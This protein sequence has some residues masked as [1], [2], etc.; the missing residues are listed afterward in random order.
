MDLTLLF[1]APFS[2]ASS[3]ATD[4]VPQR[5]PIALDG[6]PYMV[7]M[8]S[9]QTGLRGQYFR[10]DSLPVLRAQAD[11]SNTPSEASINPNDLWRRSLESWKL[12][13]GQTR[14]DRKSSDGRRFHAS[15][16][17]D[18]WS[19]DWQIS[20]LPD[21]TVARAS[22]NSNLRLVSVGT[23]CYLTDGQGLL[24]SNNLTGGAPSFTAVTGTPA[25]SASAI[26]TDGFDVYVAYGAS[27]VWTTTKAAAAATQLVTSAV[28]AGAVLGYVKGRLMC[29]SANVLYNIV[30]AAPAALP[31]ALFTHPNTDFTWVGFAEGPTSLYAAGFSGSKSLIYRTQVVTDASALAAPVVAGELPDGEIIR[32]IG[33]YLGM[34]VVG[35]DLGVRL[36]S[37]DSTGN[38]TVGGLIKTTS[39]VQALSPSS[40]FVWFSMTNYDGSSTGLGRLD[41]SVFTAPM[42]PAYAS[43]LMATG[44][45]TVRS[46]A[47]LSGVQVFTVDAVGVVV[48]SANLVPSG[49]L[50]SGLINYDLSDL[51]VAL[52]VALRTLPLVGSVGV[53]LSADSGTFVSLGAFSAE[54][55]ISPAA[56]FSCNQTL[57]ENLELRLTLNRSS[58]ATTTGPTVTRATL[59]SQPVPARSFE[60]VLPLVI[61]ERLDSYG[62]TDQ[63]MDVSDE[64]DFL[65]G[66]LTSGRLVTLQIAG[67]AFPVF[68]T[69]V[70]QLPYQL[71]S[72]KMSYDSTVIVRA[73]QPS[74]N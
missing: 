39:A 68:V 7:D 14:Y 35:S 30:S 57:A 29:G 8:T 11:S 6:H 21:T 61:H 73:L 12:G 63:V 34:M 72:N 41:L 36:C 10:C 45:G 64:T 23:Y 42:V 28:N 51:K 15:K 9:D 13:A 25:V 62:I 71:T 70:D 50:D 60:W 65:K 56:Q 4:L 52:Y 48:P 38:L 24:Y 33:G 22:S 43:D 17:V 74:T 46:V 37:V 18:V 5:Y 55:A 53:S 16:G 31:V 32:S 3:A 54:G 49:Y 69:D 59:R 44:Q 27:G 20:L 2:T 40:R 47:Q 58:T 67:Q 19:D 1:D 66:L 26:A